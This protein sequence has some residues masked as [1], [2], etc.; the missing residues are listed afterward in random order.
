MSE[1]EVPGAADA[2]LALIVESF[3]RLTGKPLLEAYDLQALWNAPFAVV[4]HAT[5]DD[6]V[7]FYGNRMALR[8]F[9][10]SFDDF[11][12]L[13]SRLSAEPMGREARAALLEKV[14]RQGFVDDYSGMRISSTNKRFMI[15]NATVW[16]LI[17]AEG[18]CHGQ[19]AAFIAPD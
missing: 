17:D 2:R 3:Q 7:F 19:A 11:T 6:P 1:P 18:I 13:S 5:E 4:A 14:R 15:T 9:E 8:L 12:R 10:M 16:N